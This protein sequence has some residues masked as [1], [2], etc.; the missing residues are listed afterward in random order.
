MPSLKKEA[1]EFN[2]LN[3]VKLKDAFWALKIKK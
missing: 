1:F 2:Y 3:K